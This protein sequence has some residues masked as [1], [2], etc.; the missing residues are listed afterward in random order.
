[1][2]C[3]VLGDPIDHSLSPVLHRAAYDALG[4]DWTYDPVREKGIDP[5][6]ERIGLR[7][8]AEAGEPLLS[9]KDTDAPTLA[10]AE[11]QGIL[12]TWAEAKALYAQLDGAGA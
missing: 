6:D 3:A 9:P 1:M 10:E 5:L 8:P 12:P 2:R 4:L 7:F 11:A